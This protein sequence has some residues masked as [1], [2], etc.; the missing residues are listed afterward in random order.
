MKTE[1]SKTW[2]RNMM[3]KKDIRRAVLQKRNELTKEE[4]EQKSNTI[5]NTLIKM[6]EYKNASII[7]CYMDFRNE[8]FTRKIMKDA[9]KAGKKIAVPKVMQSEMNFYYIESVE[10]LELGYF[11]IREPKTRKP[12][13]GEKGL[14]IVPGVAFGQKGYRIGYGKGFYDRYLN[15][16]P[17]LRKI[18]VA[19]EL[20]IVSEIPYDTHDITMD[21]IITEERKILI[22]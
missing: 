7:Y 22:K 13:N 8:V 19:F 17:I 12:A 5:C 18:A 4:L 3:E 11:G 9:W 1:V 21:M 10:D 15:K 6:K 2:V 20:Q 14:I 16:H